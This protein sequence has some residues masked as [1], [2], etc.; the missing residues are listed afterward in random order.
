MK[1]KKTRDILE[2]SL[3]VERAITLKFHSQDSGLQPCDGL[4]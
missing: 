2:G 3:Q 1:V 4:N